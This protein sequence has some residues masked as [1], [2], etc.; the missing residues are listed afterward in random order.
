MKKLLL[1]A[2]CLFALANCQNSGTAEKAA[3]SAAPTTE[4]A[5][6]AQPTC[7]YLAEG[8]DT[9]WA[10]ITV[11]TDNSVSGT[12]SWQPFESHG[13]HGTLSGKK[14]GDLLTLL[15][16]F[17]IEGSEIK[18]EMVFRLAG[19]HLAEGQ[20]ELIEGS[21]GILHLKDPATLT[22]DKKLMKTACGE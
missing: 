2:L 4:P 10:S 8:R 18:E 15:Y 14:E 20:G 1:A 11:N 16:H 22:F 6:T 9:T 21:D 13:A 3:S 7:F 12:Y 19:D 5:T 17:E